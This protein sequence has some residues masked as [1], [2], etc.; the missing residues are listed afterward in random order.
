MAKSRAIIENKYLA[1]P[2]SAGLEFDI[3]EKDTLRKDWRRT[4]SY[5]KWA[6]AVIDRDGKCQACG[7]EAH[8]HAHHLLHASHNPALRFR[9]SNGITLCQQCHS[10]FHNDFAGS[11]RVAC[12]DKMLANFF[13][14]K[15]FYAKMTASLKE[16]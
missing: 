11:T 1:I 10:S 7:E 8:L 3:P 2:D 13:A 14:V 15:S 6:D 16:A 4:S 9:V 12:D 5:R